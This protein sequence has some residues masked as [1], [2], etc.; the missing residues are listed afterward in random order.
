MKYNPQ[1]RPQYITTV[2]N[3]QKAP[4]TVENYQEP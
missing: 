1:V 4:N 2:E 3:K